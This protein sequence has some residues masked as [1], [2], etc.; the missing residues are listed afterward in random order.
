MQ[1]GN[2]G[3]ISPEMNSTASSDSFPDDAGNES[4]T[5]CQ[6]SGTLPVIRICLSRVEV[7]CRDFRARFM[8]PEAGTIGRCKVVL[9]LVPRGSCTY[10]IPSDRKNGTRSALE[11]WLPVPSVLPTDPPHKQSVSWLHEGPAMIY[12]VR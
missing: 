12:M 7:D 6:R 3:V 8:E 9:H 10:I 11:P 4:R 5:C 2:V 1:S